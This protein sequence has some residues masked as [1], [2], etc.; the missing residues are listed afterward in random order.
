M[1]EEIWVSLLGCGGEVEEDERRG[2]G[3]VW[4]GVR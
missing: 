4:G 3:C 2:L 1:L